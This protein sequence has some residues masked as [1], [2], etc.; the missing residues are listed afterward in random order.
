MIYLLYTRWGIT[1]NNHA[2]FAYLCDKLEKDYPHDF[3]VVPMNY[4]HFKHSWPSAVVPRI[5]NAL[6]RKINKLFKYLYFKHLS[7]ILKEGG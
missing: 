3:K 2:G 7:I 5:F 6:K 4:P 1:S